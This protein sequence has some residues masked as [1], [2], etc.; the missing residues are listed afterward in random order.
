MRQV[1]FHIPGVG[2]GVPG[3]GLALMVGFLLSIMWAARRALRSG[4]NP[5]IVL[6]CG[7]VAL[8]GG[9]FGSRAMFVAHYWREFA[10]RGSFW[11]V[12]G[13]IIDVR[14]G[15]LEYYGGFIA[16][17]VLTLLYLGFGRHS[18]RWYL[19]IMAPSAALGMAIGR[20]GC[21]LNG[22]C[23][24]GVCDLPWAVRF[25]FGSGAAQQQWLDRQP[26]SALPVELLAFAPGGM[27]LDGAAARP[28]AQE[29]LRVSDK[30]FA[31]ARKEQDEALARVTDLRAKLKLAADTAQTSKLQRQV[32]QAEQQ[33][34]AAGGEYRDLLLHLR[35]YGLSLPALRALAAER[36]SLPVHPAQLYSTITLGLLALLLSAVYW[37]RTRDGQVI[38][39]MLLIEPLTRWTLEL[40]RADNPQ[41]VNI[42]WLPVPLTIS[43]FL[44]VCL[45]AAGL[46]GLLWLR[47]LPPRSPRAVLWEPP[48]EERPPARKKPKGARA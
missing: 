5:D 48:P 24:G 23:F 12:A 31:E 33:A 34:V 35:R 44:A 22:C 11:Q 1:L 39:T 47:R 36:P 14:K 29:E 8:L 25:P 46:I 13:G 9:V 37:R 18:I 7:F 42:A 45:S 6:N 3:Y 19:D 30:Q 4:A 17:V 20:I 38:C 2:W 15:G 28:L 40:L 27:G 10:G 41:D 43:Q 16:V 21:F 26:G 32:T